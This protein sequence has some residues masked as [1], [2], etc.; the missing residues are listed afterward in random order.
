MAPE[1][2]KLYDDNSRNLHLDKQS[3]LWDLC[4]NILCLVSCV[5]C[6]IV[7]DGGCSGHLYL[8]ACSNSEL[9]AATRHGIS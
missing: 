1:M 6:Y 2:I 3:F 8:R 5:G 4:T 9:T 7:L